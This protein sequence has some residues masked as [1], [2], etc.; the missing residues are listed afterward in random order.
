MQLLRF[1]HAPRGYFAMCVSAC[2][3]HGHCMQNMKLHEV[4]IIRV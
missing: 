1:A 3:V 4:F 2:T